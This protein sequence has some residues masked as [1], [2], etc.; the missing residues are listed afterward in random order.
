MTSSFPNVRIELIKSP[1]CCVP[2]H[3]ATLRAL[4]LRKLHKKKEHELSPSIQGMIR[5]VSYL[6]KVENI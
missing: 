4:G 6:L 5:Q 2:K 3:K 1:I